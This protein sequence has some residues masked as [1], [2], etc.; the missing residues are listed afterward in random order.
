M[1]LAVGDGR[2]GDGACAQRPVE[3]RV[4]AETMGGGGGSHK[5]AYIIDMPCKAILF[6]AAF[7]SKWPRRKVQRERR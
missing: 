5:P 6:D 4:R 7:H 1:R 2:G 3:Y